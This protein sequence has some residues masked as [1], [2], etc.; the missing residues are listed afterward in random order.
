[1]TIL[2]P[3]TQNRPKQRGRFIRLHSAINSAV[4]W[5]TGQDRK[6]TE[7]PYIV[8]PLRVMQI[9]RSVSDNEDMLIAAV[10]HD[11]VEDT[12]VKIATIDK[13]Y[14]KSVADLVWWLTDV[15]VPEDGN[16]KTRKAI[17]REHTAN[18]PAEAQTIKLADLIDNTASITKH[19]PDFAHVYMREKEL[20]LEV[21]TLGDRKLHTQASGLVQQYQE[22]RLQDSLRNG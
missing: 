19:D 4:A 8:H 11:V 16:R 7:V 20:L 22:K 5:H 1:M 21:L 6:Y 10:L 12:Q 14:G 15:S 9:V 13:Q 2:N 18:A 17:D 3:E